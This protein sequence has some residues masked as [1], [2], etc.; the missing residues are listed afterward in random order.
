MFDVHAG[1]MYF[2]SK[3]DWWR[4]I[5]PTPQLTIS[6]TP[7]RQTFHFAKSKMPDTYVLN[8]GYMDS[9]TCKTFPFRRMISISNIGYRHIIVQINSNFIKENKSFSYQYYSMQVRFQACLVC[10]NS[11]MCKYA[12]FVQFSSFCNW[13]IF[14]QL[15]C[16]HMHRLIKH[17][18][19]MSFNKMWLY[20]CLK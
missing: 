20:N 2:A 4:V 6:D 15:K 5:D 14:V 1:K 17:T 19:Y 12:Y 8:A 13:C 7:L 11:E 18:D 10:Y 16:I 3:E 9:N